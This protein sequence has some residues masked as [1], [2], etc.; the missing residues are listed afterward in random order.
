MHMYPLDGSKEGLEGRKLAFTNPEAYVLKPQR[1]GGGNNIFRSLIPKFLKSLSHESDYNAYILMELIR[2]LTQVNYIIR[3]GK[4]NRGE[5]VN[6]L[7]IYGTIM[8][9]RNGQVLANEESGW[10]VRTKFSGN[11][12]GGISLGF[13]CSDSVCLI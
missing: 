11:D 13:G 5:V 4:L 6:E 8:W 7:G 9:N 3:E 10:Y 1:E 2:P 12:E